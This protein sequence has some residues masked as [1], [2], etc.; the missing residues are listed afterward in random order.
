MNVYYERSYDGTHSGNARPLM[1]KV[2]QFKIINYNNNE[3]F[4]IIMKRVTGFV[5]NGEYI[6]IIFA[7]IC[8]YSRKL[9]GE[10]MNEGWTLF[11]ITNHHTR[12]TIVRLHL[13]LMFPVN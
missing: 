11:E 1:S 5:R 4:C 10:N 9:R 2:G 12:K 13:L 3:S 8:E 7:G 6:I